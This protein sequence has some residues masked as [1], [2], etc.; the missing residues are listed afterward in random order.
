MSLAP[1]TRFWC[2][3][4][5][6]GGSYGVGLLC[7]LGRRLRGVL[8]GGKALMGAREN[9]SLGGGGGRPCEGRT[10]PSS[11]CSIS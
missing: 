10:A 4:K 6:E 8:A 1:G 5:M 9:I 3:K 7:V 2:R 11:Q